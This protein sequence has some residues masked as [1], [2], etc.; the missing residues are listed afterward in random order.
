VWTCGDAARGVAKSAQ[1]RISD[2]HCYRKHVSVSR[3]LE[4]FDCSLYW[5]VHWLGEGVEELADRIVPLHNRSGGATPQLLATFTTYS[6]SL[7]ASAETR[8]LEHLNLSECASVQNFE[9]KV[10]GRFDERI[11]EEEVD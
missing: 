10:C 2:S 5:T 3:S 6:S 11:D 4:V 1:D 7:N 8:N 9:D